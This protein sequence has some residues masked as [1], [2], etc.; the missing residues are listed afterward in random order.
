MAAGCSVA[1]AHIGLFERGLAQ[2]AQEWLDSATLTRQ[3]ETDGSLAAEYRR[4]DL[5][6]TLN[7]AVWGQGFAAPVFSD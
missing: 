2:I 4:V 5:V 7:Q 6:E 1:Q 3:L